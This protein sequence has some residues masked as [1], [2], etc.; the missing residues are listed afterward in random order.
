[1]FGSAIDKTEHTFYNCSCQLEIKRE[2]PIGSNGVGAPTKIDFSQIHIHKFIVLNGLEFETQQKRYA[3]SLL[4]IFNSLVKLI[5][6]IS[7]NNIFKSNN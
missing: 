6:G 4:H 1:M 3:I 2:K 5:H 7:A